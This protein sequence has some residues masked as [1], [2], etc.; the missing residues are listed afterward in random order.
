MQPHHN[1]APP[2]FFVKHHTK[3]FLACLEQLPSSAQKLDLNRMTLLYFTLAGLDAL[4]SL[5]LVSKERI[6]RWVYTMQVLPQA[7]PVTDKEFNALRGGFRPTLHAGNRPNP[8]GQPPLNMGDV[9]HITMTQ[10][11]LAILVM[12]GDDLRG[13]NKE[14]VMHHVRSCQAEDGGFRNIM[15]GSE[16]DVRFVYSACVICELLKDWSGMDVEKATDF[17]VQCQRYDGAFGE[18]PDC[19]GH[20]GTTYCALASL[21][22]LRRIDRIDIDRLVHWIVHRQILGFQGRPN[23]DQDSCYS[24]WLGASLRI[25]GAL[26]Y[27]DKDCLKEFVLACQNPKV[28]GIAKQPCSQPDL[29]HTYLPIA[30]L[31]LTEVIPKYIIREID[32]ALGFPIPK[33]DKWCKPR[34]E[35][36]EGQTYEGRKKF[37]KRKIVASP[38]K[39]VANSSPQKPAPGSPQQT[40]SSSHAATQGAPMFQWNPSTWQ[41]QMIVV[42]FTVI[43]GMLYASLEKK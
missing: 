17:L 16:A 14:A 34:T 22:L 18:R 20:G 21:A 11:A 19:E 23:K 5:H 35:A 7:D 6:T 28:G 37:Q 38:V 1:F 27:I 24:F 12:M 4:N 36:L 26:Q 3:F 30:A 9:G 33:E 10:C 39:T 29:L 41:V 32:P 40:T 43:V 15:L 13:V 42:L 25:L 2:D 31:S 8:F